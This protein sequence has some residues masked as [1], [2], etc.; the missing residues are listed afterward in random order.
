MLVR[1]KCECFIMQMLYACVLCASRG[2]PQCC[3]PHALQYVNAAR[4]CKRRPHGRGPNNAVYK[5]SKRHSLH[6]GE[7]SQ[8]SDKPCAN[9]VDYNKTDGLSP[10]T[11]KLT[12]DKSRKTQSLLSL[13]PPY[14][15]TY[16]L[17][18]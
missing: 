9:C 4:G 16:T 1:G 13:R 15:P 2:S 7:L 8:R 5:D 10:T 17:P 11:R 3:V 14:P 12:R 6:A 18:T